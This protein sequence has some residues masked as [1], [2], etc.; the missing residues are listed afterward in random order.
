MYAI[1]SYYEAEI[2]KEFELTENGYLLDCPSL[3]N[4]ND[5]LNWYGKETNGNV[6]VCPKNNTKFEAVYKIKN[7]GIGT[8][9]KVSLKHN[10][11]EYHYKEHLKIDDSVFFRIDIG[12]LKRESQSLILIFHFYDIYNNEYEQKLICDFKIEGS[13]RNNFV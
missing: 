12:K 1:R 10:N 7:F 9:M 5:V 3:V 8:A 11:A 2:D 4:E 6:A 13:Q